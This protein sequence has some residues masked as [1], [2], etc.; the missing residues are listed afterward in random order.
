MAA[1]LA[2]YY[3]APWLRWDRG[4]NA[5]GQ[6]ILID[7]PERKFYFFFIEIWPQEVYFLTGILIMMAVGLFAVTASFGRVWCGYACPQTVWT[8]L[9]IQVERM[10]EGDRN[11]RMRLDAAPMS[12]SKLGRRTLKYAIFLAISMATGGAWVL[13]FADA[14]T[15][16]HQLLA[17]DAPYAAY[18]AIA[19][20]TASTFI[21]GGLAREQVCTYMCPYARF[22]AA[23]LDEH[24]LIVA[25]RAD[26]GEPRGKHKKGESWEGHG[27]CV[28]CD[29][30]VAVCPTGIDIRDGQQLE[31]INCG[32]CADACDAVMDRVGRP[33]GLIGIDSLANVDARKQ[34]RP[35][36]TRILRTRTFIYAG[37]WCAVGLVMLGTLLLRNDIE[38]S[39]LRDRNPLFV[40]LTDGSIRNGYT[41]HIINKQHAE[42]PL[43]LSVEGLPAARV[44]VLGDPGTAP[45]A[46]MTVPADGVGEFKV[47][48]TAPRDSVKTE[49]TDIRFIVRE[50]DGRVSATRSNVFRGPSR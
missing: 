44:S 24:S 27:D 23:M 30:C 33:R 9:F 14:P 40:P 38:V 10:I 31:C 2:V 15:L 48:V 45:V 42:R 36:V 11:A 39:A 28:D 4:P 37:I 34:G 47:F 26:R 49:S 43:A 29:S 16:A 21:L 41:V 13:Y 1:M 3:L 46:R 17:F 5:P 25:Y 50:V 6:A 19:F 8:D 22:Q 18:A 7:F 12:V 32:L 35:A 20:L